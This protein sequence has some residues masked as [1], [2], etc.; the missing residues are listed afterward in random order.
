MKVKKDKER[1]LKG[2]RTEIRSNFENLYFN[3]EHVQIKLAQDQELIG[4]SEI[5]QRI[6]PRYILDL[7]DDV[8]SDNERLL[9]DYRKMKATDD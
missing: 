5:H 8:D 2:L 9:G 6:E 1:I 7:E 3:K 4:K